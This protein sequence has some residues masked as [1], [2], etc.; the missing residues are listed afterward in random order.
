M[1][2][3]STASLIAILLIPAAITIVEQRPAQALPHTTV[4]QSIELASSFHLPNRG[5]PGRREGGGT[6]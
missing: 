1:H 2:I 4:Q 3:P 5:L 6:R